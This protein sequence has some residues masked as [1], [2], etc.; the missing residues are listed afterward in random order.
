M[1]KQ[2]P[3]DQAQRRHSERFRQVST[4]YP[5]MVALAYARDLDRAM[6][7]SDEQVAA[8]VAAWESAQGEVPR[9]WVAIGTEESD[10]S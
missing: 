5:R 4:L 9:D 2:Q 6:V 3:N 8:T 7:D 1:D 10:E